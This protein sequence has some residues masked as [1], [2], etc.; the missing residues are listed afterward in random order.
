MP[1]ITIHYKN[2]ACCLLLWRVLEKHGE[3]QGTEHHLT[4]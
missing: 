3:V 2:D 4:S 1:M